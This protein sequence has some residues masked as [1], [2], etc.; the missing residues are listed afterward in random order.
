MTL[1]TSSSNDTSPITRTNAAWSIATLA[2]T[3][4]FGRLAPHDLANYRP[5]SNDEGEL[6]AVSYKLPTRGV[7]GSDLAVG[8]FGP[9]QRY[10]ETLPLQ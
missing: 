8:V 10:L 9:D 3:F 1:A 7:L 2:I 5:W 6:V 4:A